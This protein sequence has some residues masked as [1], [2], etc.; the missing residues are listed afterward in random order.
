MKQ[1]KEQHE[2]KRARIEQLDKITQIL[3]KDKQKADEDVKQL[4][5]ENELLKVKLNDI[6]MS[7]SMPPVQPV[8]AT[9]GTCLFVF[10]E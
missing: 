9:S 5:S 4:R 10:H 1:I 8:V 2:K 7:A 3:K 6:E